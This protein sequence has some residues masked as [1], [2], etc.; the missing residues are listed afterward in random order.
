MGWFWSCNTKK[1]IRLKDAYKE[2]E[3][4]YFKI[5]EKTDLELSDAKKKIGV[6]STVGVEEARI[7]LSKKAEDGKQMAKQMSWWDL[8]FML[9]F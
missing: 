5:K 1:C 7:L 6:F 8:I 2:K 4:I 9:N 3:Q